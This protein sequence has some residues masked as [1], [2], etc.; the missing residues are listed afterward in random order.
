LARCRDQLER[1]DD[2]VTDRQI[3]D[4]LLWRIRVDTHVVDSG[5]KPPAPPLSYTFAGCRSRAGFSIGTPMV[6]PSV[7]AGLERTVTMPAGSKEAGQEPPESSGL[8]HADI[9]I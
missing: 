4:L 6:A 2:I 3:M 1:T 7:R 9:G 8:T 5:V